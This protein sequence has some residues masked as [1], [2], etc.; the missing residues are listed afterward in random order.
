MSKFYLQDFKKHCSKC[1]LIVQ[2]ILEEIKVFI[3][4][5]MYMFIFIALVLK[6]YKN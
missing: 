5:T 1:A 4:T 3:K 2:K 6:K